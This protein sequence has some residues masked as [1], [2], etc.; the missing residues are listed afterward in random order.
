[1]KKL[2]FVTLITAYCSLLQAQEDVPKKVEYPTN[3][4]AQIDAVYATVGDWQG[5]VDLYYP[6]TATQPVPVIINIHGGGWNHGTKESQSGFN[7]FFKMGFAV[8]N[9]EYRLTQQ[10]VAPAAVEDVRCAMLHVVKHAAELNIDPHKIIV[11]GG[12]AGGH[13]A[14]M[15]GL[16]QHN[17]RFDANCS[18]VDDFTIIAIVDKYGIANLNVPEMRKYKS[19][20]NW[21]GAE[22]DNVDFVRAMSPISY[23][24]PDSPP[25]FIVHG[26]A[27][28]IVPYEQSV[29]LHR[30]LEA[31]GVRN[32]FITVEGGVHGKFEKEKNSEIN[33]AI[34]TFLKEL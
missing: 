32:E 13:L 18:G 5:R 31:A 12:S 28:P 34:A 23:V 10:A 30:A 15:A 27:D 4:T 16:L 3:Y 24:T 29:E 6:A 21:L 9:V 2:L 19:A 17:H 7:T 33:R 1:M 25:V 26:N 20:R 22:V 14:L 11:M 8:A